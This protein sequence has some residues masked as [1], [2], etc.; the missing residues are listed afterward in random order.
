LTSGGNT[1]LVVTPTG[2]DINGTIEM[3][4][5]LSA[6]NID[7]TGNVEANVANIASAIYLGTSQIV[8]G[9]VTTTSIT[10]NQT[11]AT[12]PVSGVT[13]VEWIVK[14]VDSTG[15]KY[16]MATV[17]AVTNGTTVDY[18]INGPVLIGG[19]TGS[20]AVN[21]VSGNIALQV[22]PSSG[23]STVWTTQFRMI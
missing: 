16:T 7:V 1:T 12:W 5:N 17:Q 11:I 4:G 19:T 13:G 15:S 10:A 8:I 9:T 23:N 6:D 20:L 22:T 18:A 3:S 21:I 2:I 14:G